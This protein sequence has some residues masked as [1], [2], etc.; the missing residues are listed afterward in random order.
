MPLKFVTQ[1]SHT[2]SKIQYKPE[3]NRT[4]TPFMNKHLLSGCSTTIR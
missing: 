3:D 2:S 4:F 1:T